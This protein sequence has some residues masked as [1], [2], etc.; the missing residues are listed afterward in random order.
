MDVVILVYS[1]ENQQSLEALQDCWVTEFATFSD[2]SDTNWIIVGNKN[3]LRLDIDQQTIKDI[4]QRLPNS[5]ALFTSAHTGNNV[6]ELFE[7]A[8]KK[9]HEV[10]KRKEGTINLKDQKKRPQVADSERKG[11]C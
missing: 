5:V 11:C 7:L 1:V 8:I 9:G 2:I 10:R 6:K 3:D 4:S